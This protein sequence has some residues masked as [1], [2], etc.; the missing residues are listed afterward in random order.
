MAITYLWNGLVFDS[1][2][3]AHQHICLDCLRVQLSGCQG[4]HSHFSFE[5]Y[6]ENTHK[7]GKILQELVRGF[8]RDLLVKIWL[9]C[10]PYIPG[11]TDPDDPF[12]AM[13]EEKKKQLAWQKS[14]GQKHA[15]KV[16]IRTKIR[17]IC[18]GEKKL[19]GSFMSEEI[20]KKM[21]RTQLFS[22]GHDVSSSVEYTSIEVQCI[23]S[24]C[25]CST[26]MHCTT[27]EV[28]MLQLHCCIAV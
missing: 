16:A 21:Q 14:S 8:N 17:L 4:L 25:Q 6:S 18:V 23:G 13:S 5:Q 24:A 2:I 22:V 28:H 1:S 15:S 26:S 12:F 7:F 19:A 11:M 27:Y 20:I 10:L 9:G 3:S